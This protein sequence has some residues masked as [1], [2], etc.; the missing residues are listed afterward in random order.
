MTDRRA[1][2]AIDGPAGSGKSTTAR[3]VAEAL[4]YTHLDSGA[5]YRAV[6]LVGLESKRP[7]EQWTGEDLVA[8]AL[9]KPVAVRAQGGVFAVRIGA[10][11]AEPAIRADA[12]TATVSRVAAMPRVREFVNALLRGAGRDGGVVMD[13]RDIGSVVFPDAEVKIF[14][15]ADPAERAR[16]RLLERGRPSNEESIRVE[17]G[18]LLARDAHD[19]QRVIAPL[20]RPEGALELDTTALSIEEQVAKVV[21]L[22]RAALAANG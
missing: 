1:I 19:S 11:D 18:A 21:A 3:A 13:G 5:V 2:I 14:M 4:G 12:V 7:P 22:A 6:T 10:A 15:I 20:A 8:A 16:R 17:A 9:R